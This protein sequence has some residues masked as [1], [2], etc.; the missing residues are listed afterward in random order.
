MKQPIVTSVRFKPEWVRAY[1]RE[2]G[3]SR[4]SVTELAQQAV[5]AFGWQMAWWTCQLAPDGA[6]VLLHFRRVTAE[7]QAAVIES[8]Q[9][10]AAGLHLN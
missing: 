7:E 10:A 2:H 8:R 1:L 3:R 4:E 6:P 9:A 5:A